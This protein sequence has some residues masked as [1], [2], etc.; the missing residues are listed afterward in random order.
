MRHDQTRR[1]PECPR[2]KSTNTYTDN[3]IYSANHK[4]W[5]TG[6]ICNSCGIVTLDFP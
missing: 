6:F 3:Q 5:K 2:C 1:R 4:A